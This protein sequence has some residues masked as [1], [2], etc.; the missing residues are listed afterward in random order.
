LEMVA[1]HGNF[2][3][4]ISVVRWPICDFFESYV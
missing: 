3:A 1:E 4:W 2:L